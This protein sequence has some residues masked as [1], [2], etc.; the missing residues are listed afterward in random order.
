MRD[1]RAVS[2]NRNLFSQEKKNLQL[3]PCQKLGYQNGIPNS[4]LSTPY[5]I[6]PETF[7]NPGNF[8]LI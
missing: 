4:T 7:A 6:D 1:Y 5:V 2:L 3:P 8:P